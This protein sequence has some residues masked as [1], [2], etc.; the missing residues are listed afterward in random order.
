[1]SGKGKKDDEGF[2]MLYGH[3]K[4]GLDYIVTLAPVDQGEGV[5][6]GDSCVFSHWHE[7]R[8]AAQ[9]VSAIQFEVKS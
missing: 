2:D 4:D 1:M 5:E 6:I 7:A 3:Y 8:E 9:K